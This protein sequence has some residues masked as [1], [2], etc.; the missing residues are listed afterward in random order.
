MIDDMLLQEIYSLREQVKILVKMLKYYELDINE[1]DLLHALGHCDYLE[2]T[3][4]DE[5]HK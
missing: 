5:V 3:E 1:F 4:D 2:Y